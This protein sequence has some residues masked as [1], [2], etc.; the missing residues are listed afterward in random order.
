VFLFWV[1][2]D[3][4]AQLNEVTMIGHDDFKS[5]RERPEFVELER[6]IASKRASQSK[7]HE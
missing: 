6:E 4:P 1:G 2:G 5:I 7:Q 3:L